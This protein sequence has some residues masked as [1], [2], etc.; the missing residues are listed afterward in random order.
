MFDGPPAPRGRGVL[1]L[2]GAL[3]VPPIADPLCAPT[4]Q[5][6]RMSHAAMGSELEVQAYTRDSATLN[7]VVAEGFAAVDALD[8]RWSLYRA[9]SELSRLNRRASSGE[10]VAL[11]PDLFELLQVSADVHRMTGGAFDVT[12]GPLVRLWGFLDGR[13]HWPRPEELE[14]CRQRTGFENVALDAEARTLRFL[15]PAMEIDLGG[16][17]KGY[18]VDLL[19]GRLHRAGVERFLVDF[20]GSSQLASGSPPGQDGWYLYL[21]PPWNDRLP[22]R[23]VVARD[24][25]LSTSSNDQRFWVRD[26]RIYGHVLDPRTGLPTAHRGS[27]S[28]IAPSATLSD[29]L[30]TA[31]L[32]L[33]LEEAAR[34]VHTH[35][36]WRAVFYSPRDGWREIGVAPPPAPRPPPAPC[37]A[38]PNAGTGGRGSGG[39]A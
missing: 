21:R 18:A 12:V 4:E 22:M 3:A 29:A 16:V 23:K 28:V 33:G 25:S 6:H 13:P 30:S 1:L 14:A 15:R 36:E 2:A 24:L 20:G 5:L 11:E 9:D 35:P 19:A 8:A 37:S 26:G 31:F 38:R 34:V 7:R 32:V 10:V 17:A 39:N 27:V